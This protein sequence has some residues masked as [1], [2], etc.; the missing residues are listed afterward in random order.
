VRDIRPHALLV[1]T[2]QARHWAN[3][4]EDVGAG[5]ASSRRWGQN[6]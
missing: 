2:A 5:V 4:G 6:R 3:S 1:A